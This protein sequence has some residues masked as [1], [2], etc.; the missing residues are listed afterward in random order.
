MVRQIKGTGH[1]KCDWQRNS[2]C[3]YPEV[4]GS[5]SYSRS[6][7]STGCNRVKGKMKDETRPQK[8]RVFWGQFVAAGKSLFCT[9]LPTR[10]VA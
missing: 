2:I 10:V 8:T 5:M 3:K 9:S 1:W 7:K 4:W 6:E